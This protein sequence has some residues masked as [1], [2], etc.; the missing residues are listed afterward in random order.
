MSGM[1]AAPWEKSFNTGGS[2][3]LHRKL[4]LG[5]KVSSEK[6]VTKCKRNTHLL[7]QHHSLISTPV[8]GSNE[9]YHLSVNHRKTPGRSSL[10]HAIC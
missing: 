3:I 4:R 8:S 7:A 6:T 9:K 10:E 1:L 5:Y 2:T